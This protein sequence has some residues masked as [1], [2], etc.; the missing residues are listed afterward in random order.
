MFKSRKYPREESRQLIA[1]LDIGTSKIAAVIGEKAEGN[2]ILISGAGVSASK[3][4]R[5]GVVIHFEEAVQSIQRAVQEAQ[6]TAGVELKNVLVG[7][8]GDHIHSV[9]SRGVVVVSGSDRE[10]TGDDRERVLQAART[11]ALP[12]ERKVIH[13]LQQEYIVD[14]QTG[15][16]N[17]VGL[18]GVRLEAEVHIVTCAAAQA[19]NLIRAVEEAGLRTD[20][21]VLEPLASSYSVLE[22][23]EKK[24]GVV[25]ID[26]GGGT[27]DIAMF[28]NDTIRHTAIVPL[29][30]QNV[31]ND[32]AIG[33]KTSV[34]DAEEIK[35]M[36]G[37]AHEELVPRDVTLSTAP[38]G[39]RGPKEVSRELLATII[40]PRMEEIFSLALKEIKRSEYEDK[41]DAGVVLT[42]GGSLLKGVAEVAE[43]VFQLPVRLG[44]PKGFGGL[45]ESVA[46]PIYAT[47][48]GLVLF[49]YE[50][51]LSEGLREEGSAFKGK[52]WIHSTWN[53]FRKEFLS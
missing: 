9:N 19:Q 42:G 44:L 53:R 3:G 48:V 22:P 12:A 18:N 36:H 30:G 41:M 31:T 28:Y 43:E 17:P 23:D 32:I 38:F 5:Q 10:I 20:G 7:I 13:V 14:N 50:T 34:D 46:S 52:N 21:L 25:L 27:T 35:R 11:I 1:G 39:G 40:Q 37:C 26:I 47:G 51:G 16:K 15:I 6:L 33:L 45:T 49:G 24:L 8:A 4:F 29:G 2:R